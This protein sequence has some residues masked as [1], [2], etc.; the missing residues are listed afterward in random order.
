L[1]VFN[2]KIHIGGIFF[3]T[4]KAFDCMNHGMLLWEVNLCGIHSEGGHP[5]CFQNSINDVCASLNKWFKAYK[6]TLNFGKTD[7]MKFSPNN[8][9]SINLNIDYDSK[10]TEEVGTAKF[11]GSQIYNNWNLKGDIEYII[12]KLIS[13]F[14]AMRTVTQLLKVDTSE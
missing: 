2:G 9:T 6:F 4:A 14:F 1:C 7:F 5:D 8:K 11:L 10:T 3:G 13:A 12:P